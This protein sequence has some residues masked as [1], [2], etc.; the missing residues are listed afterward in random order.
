MFFGGHNPKPGKTRNT[1]NKNKVGGAQGTERVQKRHTLSLS[2]SLSLK[3]RCFCKSTPARPAVLASLP[4][5]PWR[6]SCASTAYTRA[7][8]STNRVPGRVE[9]DPENKGLLA[10]LSFLFDPAAK[11]AGL[12]HRTVHWLK[13]DAAHV[14]HEKLGWGALRLAAVLGLAVASRSSRTKHNDLQMQLVMAPG[15]GL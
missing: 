6:W 15:V 14:L 3:L 8:P 10:K 2:L 12:W 7:P 11:T 4:R 5:T 9:N 13:G 1:A